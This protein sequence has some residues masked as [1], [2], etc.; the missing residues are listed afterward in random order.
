MIDF[1]RIEKFNLIK[2]IFMK[3]F[4]NSFFKNVSLFREKPNFTQKP[5]VLTFKK[6]GQEIISDGYTFF[7]TQLHLF[8]AWGDFRV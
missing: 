4:R 3:F 7:F 8:Q 1:K 6:K 2:N 5:Q